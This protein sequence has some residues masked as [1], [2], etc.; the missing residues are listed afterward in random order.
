MTP[1]LAKTCRKEIAVWRSISDQ[2]GNRTINFSV[3]RN[4]FVPANSNR[5]AAWIR[6]SCKTATTLRRMATLQ[7]A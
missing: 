5:A 6:S 7:L 4:H 2:L 1:D 3:A